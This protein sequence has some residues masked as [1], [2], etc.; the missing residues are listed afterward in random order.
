[1]NLRI[2]DE[3][4]SAMVMALGTMMILAVVALS[5]VAVVTAEKRTGFSAYAGARSFYSADAA[6]EAGV[7]WMR[8]QYSPPA[9]VDTASNVRVANT[10]TTTAAN[11]R[12]KFDV[13]YVRKRYRSGWSVEYKDYEYRVDAVGASTQQ[14]ETD[15][16]LRATRLYREGY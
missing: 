4:G 14:A 2:S 11:D 13:K 3:R 16:E 15:V 1:M 8:H 5:I 10:Y 7:N 9:L 12:Y 6:T